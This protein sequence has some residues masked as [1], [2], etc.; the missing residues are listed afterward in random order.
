MY[1]VTDQLGTRWGVTDTAAQ[2]VAIKMDLRADPR[3]HLRRFVV[4]E[5][6]P[7]ANAPIPGWMPLDHA[8]NALLGCHWNR[9]GR[10]PAWRGPIRERYL[11]TLVA[12]R[13]DPAR[14]PG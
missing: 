3:N 11:N 4:R 10:D 8:R 13:L 14:L 2:A 7:V 12:I 1:Q 5:Q 6:R 9:V